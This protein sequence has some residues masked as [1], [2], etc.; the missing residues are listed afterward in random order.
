MKYVGV[1][2]EGDRDYDMIE[3][4]I[5]RFIEEETR[6]LWL[7]PNPEFGTQINGA[8]WKGVLRW[9]E[10][11]A[12]DLDEYLRCITPKI[13]ALVI[14]ID[15]DVARCEE[16]VFCKLIPSDCPNQREA[17]P[18]ICDTAIK[19]KCPQIL[20]PNFLCDGSPIGLATYLKLVLKTY[21]GAQ[22]EIPVLL[23]PCDA[24]D[25]WILAAFEENGLNWEAIPDPWDVITKRKDYHGIRIP[26]RK[27]VKAPYLKMINVVCEK[28]ETVKDRCPQ[29]YQ[30]EEELKR[31]LYRI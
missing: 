8:G 4:V 21:L 5:S 20:P 14:Q 18:L 23:I 30:F 13:D 2:C 15:A 10:T 11:H 31:K 17:D 3:N 6:C 28:W 22:K 26:K 27:K 16:E 19:G 25:T 29:A 24:S 7:Q 1:V 9:C 12:L